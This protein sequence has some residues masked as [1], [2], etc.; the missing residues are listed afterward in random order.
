[1][2]ESVMRKDCRLKMTKLNVCTPAMTLQTKIKRSF[3]HQIIPY[4]YL[5]W[6]VNILWFKLA[7]TVKIHW[8]LTDGK[9]IDPTDEIPNAIECYNTVSVL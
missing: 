9:H 2:V 4:F 1:M 7:S 6:W 5:V 8:D 3:L